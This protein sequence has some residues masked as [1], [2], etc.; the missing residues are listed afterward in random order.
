M[1]IQGAA[2]S[3]PVPAH[4]HAAHGHRGKCPLARSCGTFKGNAPCIQRWYAAPRKMM[5]SPGRCTTPAKNTLVSLFRTPFPSPPLA[6]VASPCLGRTKGLYWEARAPCASG[7]PYSLPSSGGPGPLFLR[8]EKERS[9][10][11]IRIPAWSYTWRGDTRTSP[12]LGTLRSGKSSPSVAS[13]RDSLR[14]AQHSLPRLH[15]RAN[16]DFISADRQTRC[17]APHAVLPTRGL[18]DAE[19]DSVQPP[20]TSAAA[21]TARFW[22]TL[23]SMLSQAE[24]RCGSWSRWSFSTLARARTFSGVSP[25]AKRHASCSQSP[26]SS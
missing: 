1:N 13:F 20:Q 2:L 22:L 11:F 19:L 8:G 5:R 24:L 26:G 16:A 6:Y 3:L 4:V 10:T 9:R 7:S 15:G 18:T 12:K 14:R 21:R 17:S 25:S 23:S